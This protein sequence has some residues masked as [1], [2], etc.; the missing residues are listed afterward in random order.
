M[1]FSKR[2]LRAWPMHEMQNAL[3]V[4]SMMTTTPNKVVNPMHASRM[5]V[6]L[7]AGDYGTWLTGSP[8]EAARNVASWLSGAY[9]HGRQSTVDG[10]ADA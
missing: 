3:N 10:Y 4:F 6:I 7:D 2:L 1:L 5:P 8:D 9:C